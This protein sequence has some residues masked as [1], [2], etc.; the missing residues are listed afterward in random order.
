LPEQNQQ[1]QQSQQQLG[2]SFVPRKGMNK[3]LIS[4][5][6]SPETW[7][8]AKNCINSSQSGDQLSLLTES[9]N[10]LCI[11][12]PYQLIGAIPLDGGQWM[13]FCTDDI[14]SEIGVVDTDN[15][16]YTRFSNTPCLGFKQTNL[17]TGA[18]RRN[19]DCGFNVYW[20]D[21][22]LNPDRYVDTNTTNVNNLIWV[23]N[24]TTT[25]TPSP[26]PG[27]PS[28]ECTTCINTDI[29]NCNNIRIA[30][31]VDIPNVILNKSQGAGTLENGTYQVAIAYV[32]NDIKV[33]DYIIVSN[34]QA[35]FSHN[36]EAG[37]IVA[38]ITG[39]DITH[40]KQMLITVISYNNSQLV[41]RR[42]GIFDTTEQTII[43]DAVPP[44]LPLEPLSNI[45]LQTPLV[46]KSDSIWAVNQYLLRNGIYERPDPN[47]QLIANNITVNWALV[48]YPEKYYQGTALVLGTNQTFSG[49]NYSYMSDEQY[50]FFIRGVYN[51]GDKTASYHIPGR[52]YNASTDSA[53]QTQ[54]T[55]SL[56]SIPYSLQPD[57]GVL[58]ATGLMGYWQSTEQYPSEQANVWGTLCGTPIRHHKFPDQSVNTILSHFNSNGINS[59][60][61]VYGVQ[62]SNIQ[63]FV[64]INNNIIPD[65]V[66]YEILRGSRE[67]NKSIIA[68]GIINNMCQ[69]PLPGTS[70]FGLFQNYPANDLRT[71]NYLTA[72]QGQINIGGTDGNIHPLSNQILYDHV[73]FHS[74]DTSF[75]HP[76]LGSP[77]L[78]L[79]QELDGTQTGYFTNPYK[80][81]L[82][83]IVTNLDSVLTDLIAAIA[84]LGDLASALGGLDFGFAPTQGLPFNSPLGLNL[85]LPE[86]TDG[87]LA[88]A[89]YAVQVVYNA[90]LVILLSPILVE[91]ISQQLLNVINGIIPGVQ[92]AYQFNGHSYYNQ[93]KWVSNPPTVQVNDYQYIE[94]GVQTFG[95]YEVNNLYRNNYVALALQNPIPTPNII[96]KT[97]YT[98]TQAPANRNTSSLTTNTSCFYTGLKVAFGSQYGQIGSVRQLPIN[99]GV[100]TGTQTPILF[101]GDT[102]VNRYT[103]KNPMY[104]FNDW[105]LDVAEDYSY[106]YRNYINV[107]YPAFWIDN[108]KV[109]QNGWPLAQNN[110]RLENHNESWFYVSTGFFYLFCNGV[111]DFFVE[112]DVNVGFRDWGDSISQ[113]FYDPYGFA[114]L[115][116]MFRSDIM[117][118]DQFYKYD[119]SLSINKFYSQYVSFGQTLDVDY[120]P[121]L[122]YTCFD[123]YPRRIAYSLPQTEEQKV[124][125]WRQFLANNYYDFPTPITAVKPTD[126]TGALFLM[127]ESSPVEFKGVQILNQNQPNSTAITIG[128]GGLFNQPLQ[129]VLNT[130]RGINYGSCTSK[131]ASINTPH[132]LFFVSQQSGKVFN[133][134]GDAATKYHNQGQLV[135][136]SEKGLKWWFAKYMPS[137]LLA[138]FPNYPL[139]DNTVVGIG[140]QMS[141]DET[142][143]ILYISKKDYQAKSNV[144]YS[145]GIFY[146]NCPPGTFVGA[147]EPDGTVVCAECFPGSMCPGT[148]I[149]LGDPQ[150]FIDTSWTISFDCKNNYWISFHSWQPKFSLTARNHNIT[151]INNTLWTHNVSTS[152][153]ANYYRVQYPTNVEFIANTQPDG[154]TTLRNIE[155]TLDSWVYKSNGWDRFQVYDQ[156]FNTLIIYN[157]EQV[158]GLLNLNPKP[159]NPYV[160]LNYPIYNT[161]SVD[162]LYSLKER[163]YRINMFSDLTNDRGEFTNAQQQSII[164]NPN[165][166]DFQLNTSAINYAK[167]PLQQKKFRSEFNKIFLQKNSPAQYRLQFYLNKTQ[168]QQSN[169]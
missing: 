3:D 1:E 159:T 96:D 88:E 47:Y 7:T 168:Q 161:S 34:S 44:T 56:L 45:P 41:A 131:F 113:R 81:P 14:N 121:E 84:V 40:F 23:Q 43:I 68:K 61:N 151:N 39:A 140:M 138:Q 160:E 85:N 66:G 108:T 112:S 63:P 13:V 142:N 51:T 18:A 107:P 53:W 15:C 144:A 105:L 79:Y 162:I 49:N 32:V 111:R 59:Y 22:G 110:R 72:D 5:L 38:T 141:Y 123:Y 166:V 73:S 42:L 149:T 48:Q 76:Y 65:I 9:A 153:F 31:L 165:G 117:K 8:S 78:K 10:Q 16:L 83:K 137:T 167:P 74:P 12:L 147:I 11:T 67:G 91:T 71:D 75:Q 97:R 115:G 155:Y 104:F 80:H 64:D 21:G 143:D 132:G 99:T 28:T 134:T 152:L 125:N 100:L 126:K 93:Y 29:L 106:N 116:L 133:Y 30:P 95:N 127:K 109:Y 36:N 6:Q 27:Q 57:G 33:T 86:G 69:Y 128:D 150:Y 26:I 154:F 103:E 17:I 148:V 89:L 98:L 2:T 122:A 114:D 24:C 129:N 146:A 60:V 54:N 120:D 46:D 163:K 35:I 77:A 55:A 135:E 37:A 50:C 119:Y 124:D 118:S 136:I 102:Y 92:Y 169:R 25:T 62:F 4:Y 130:E 70:Q 82:F 90:S 157:N 145:N 19:F 156:N 164:T 101:G 94:G 87:A 20:S 139:Y 158:S 52:A 58:L